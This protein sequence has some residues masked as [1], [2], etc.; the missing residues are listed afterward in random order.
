MTQVAWDR[1]AGWIGSRDRTGS[2]AWAWAKTGGEERANGR[3]GAWGLPGPGEGRPEVGAFKSKAEV[4]GFVS[5]KSQPI[6]YN[7]FIGK[8][9]KVFLWKVRNS[10]PL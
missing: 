5:W 2:A 1:D 4:Q 8:S 7:F 10:T 6:F 9:A 3:L